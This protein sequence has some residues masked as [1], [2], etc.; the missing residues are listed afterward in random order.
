M[1]II[2]FIQDLSNECWAGYQQ[3]G[4]VLKIGTEDCA[5]NLLELRYKD[6]PNYIQVYTDSSKNEIFLNY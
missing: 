3:S 2:K 4:N 5:V 1:A 6:S